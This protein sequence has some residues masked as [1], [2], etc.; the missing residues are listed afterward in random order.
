MM[1]RLPAYPDIAEH[2]YYV[3]LEGVEYLVRLTWRERQA[4]WYM[5]LL[6]P[7]DTPVAVGRRLSP[8]WGPVLGWR[9][10]HRPEGELLVVGPSPYQRDDLGDTLH[11]YYL[12]EDEWTALQEANR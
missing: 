7:P 6:I 9:V 8:G 5:D 1:R 11:L 12:P 4:S 2:E 3:T 10:E